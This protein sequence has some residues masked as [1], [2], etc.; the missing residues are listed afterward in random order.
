MLLQKT[1]L[2]TVLIMS[3]IGLMGGIAG[4]IS[5]MRSTHTKEILEYFKW[6]KKNGMM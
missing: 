5:Y 1:I 6:L 3:L 2:A 4:L